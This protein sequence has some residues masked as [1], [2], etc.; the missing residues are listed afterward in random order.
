MSLIF[1][2]LLIYF[3]ITATAAAYI[4]IN[5]ETEIAYRVSNP[6]SFSILFFHRDRS[7]K[8]AKK[9]AEDYDEIRWQHVRLTFF[10]PP[11]PFSLFFSELRDEQDIKVVEGEFMRGDAG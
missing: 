7:I 4:H 1:I 3:L 2:L 10:K 11:F 6:D 5:K 9:K 8:I